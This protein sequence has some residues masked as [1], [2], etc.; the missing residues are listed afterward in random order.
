[1]EMAG[2]SLA[3]GT[4]RGDG[5]D[6]KPAT[7]DSCTRRLR[8]PLLVT[9]LPSLCALPAVP[10]AG[11]ASARTM[12]TGC[13]MR[14]PPSCVIS[15]MSTRR[16][17]YAICG[18]LFLPVGEDLVRCKGV[19]AAVDLHGLAM[20]AMQ[21]GPFASDGGS[22]DHMLPAGGGSMVAAVL[23]SA[24]CLPT[25][26]AV[27]EAAVVRLPM[28]WRGCTLARLRGTR[29]VAALARAVA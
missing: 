21:W 4:G 22:T 28:A 19:D 14:T 25:E 9:I 15:C 23:G 24:A 20:V 12:A 6:R 8:P 13:A 29:L 16:R 7:G 17:T 26:V 18:I 10:A 11:R 1:M 3:R 27:L 2:G 5:G